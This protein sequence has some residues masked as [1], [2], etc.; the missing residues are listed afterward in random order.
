MGEL[1]KTLLTTW[2]LVL[3]AVAVAVL[4]YQPDVELT[5][6]GLTVKSFVG[7]GALFGMMQLNNV[8]VKAE[9]KEESE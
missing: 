3:G 7:V 4:S 6:T 2:T 8:K 5:T 9:L 1:K